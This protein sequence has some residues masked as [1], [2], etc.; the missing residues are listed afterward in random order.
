MGSR[1]N[2]VRLAADLGV[3]RAPVREALQRLAEEGLVVERPHLGAIVRELDASS[4]VDLYTVRAAIESLA[5]RLATARG[6]GT[7][8]LRDLITRMGAAARA[9]NATLVARH[10]LEFHAAIT[11]EC[12]NPLLI[13][14]FHA[15]EGQVLM[16]LALDDAGYPDLREVA[17]EHEPLVKVIE[18]GDSELAATMM[19]DHILST[20]GSLVARL[21]G[22]GDDLRLRR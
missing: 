19:R 3:S 18:S 12:G 8:Q 22:S 17:R 11:N 4:I 16:G 13:G 5:I 10:E 7:K 20:L 9:A 6:M 1:L 2:E 14:I 15:L 21:G